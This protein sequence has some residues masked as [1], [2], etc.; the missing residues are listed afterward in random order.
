[1]LRLNFLFLLAAFTFANCSSTVSVQ[2]NI[3][4]KGKRI[5]MGNF[6]IEPM[7][8]KGTATDTVCACV[9]QSIQGTLTPYLQ[10]AGFSIVTLPLTHKTTLLETMHIADSMQVDYIMTGVGLVDIQGSNSFVRE[11]SVKAVNQ[12]GEVVLSGSFT[13]VGTGP[14]KAAG[15]IGKQLLKKLK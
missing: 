5:G 2:D 1:M 15:K 12:S 7:K 9:G 3:A 13:G 14:A 6:K 11:L 10:E 8:K 4:A